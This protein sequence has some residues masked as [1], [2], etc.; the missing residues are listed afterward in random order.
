VATQSSELA[1]ERQ[2]S[3]NK[4]GQIVALKKRHDELI[5]LADDRLDDAQAVRR[6]K[7]VLTDRV[8]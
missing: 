7:A 8:V 3:D 2:A 6:E 5:Q 4:A 1:R